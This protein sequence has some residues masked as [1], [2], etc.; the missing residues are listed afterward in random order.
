MKS[1]GWR[2]FCAQ[3]ARVN[4][5]TPHAVHKN[6]PESRLDSQPGQA[7]R[8]SRRDGGFPDIGPIFPTLARACREGEAP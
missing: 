1:P 8:L 3:R 4:R 7:S 2:G 5:A 6:A